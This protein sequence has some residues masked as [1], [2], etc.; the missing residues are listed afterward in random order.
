MYRQFLIIVIQKHVGYFGC[1]ILTTPIYRARMIPLH[2]VSPN[3]NRVYVVTYVNAYQSKNQA[4]VK[5]S[6]FTFWQLD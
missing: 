5:N 6:G 3:I 1:V 4:L 2:Y